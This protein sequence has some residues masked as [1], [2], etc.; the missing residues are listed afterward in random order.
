MQPDNV[1]EEA[2]RKAAEARDKKDQDYSNM[3]Q[4]E[5]NDAWMELQFKDIAGMFRDYSKH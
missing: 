2:L 1:Y 5:G 3:L 4:G